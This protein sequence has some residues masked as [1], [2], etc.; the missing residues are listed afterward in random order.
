MIREMNVRGL[1]TPEEFEQ[2]VNNDFIVPHNLI[3]IDEQDINR[4]CSKQGVFDALRIESSQASFG[5][6]L[7]NGIKRLLAAHDGQKTQC[8]MLCH[9]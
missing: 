2:I 3:N 8:V 4:F 7:L 9:C 6:D 1:S 5:N